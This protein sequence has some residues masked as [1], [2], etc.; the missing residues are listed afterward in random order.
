[1]KEFKEWLILNIG[2]DYSYFVKHCSIEEQE[3]IWER[4]YRETSEK[5]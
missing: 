5:T 3:E 4:Y 1:M 2:W